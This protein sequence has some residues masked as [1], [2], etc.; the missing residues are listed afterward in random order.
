MQTYLAADF[1]ENSYQPLLVVVDKHEKGMRF[2][3]IVYG[4]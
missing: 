1:D 4:I 2:L 3:S